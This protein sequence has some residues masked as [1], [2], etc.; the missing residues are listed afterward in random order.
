M[1]KFKRILL[2][3]ISLFIT[4]YL[5]FL[6]PLPL[7]I[8]SPGT[9]FNLKEMIEVDNQFSKSTTNLFLTTV[10]IRQATVFT[11][12]SSVLPFRDLLKEKDLFGEIDN[13]DEYNKVQKIYMENSIHNAIK[14]AFTQAGKDFQMEYKGIYVMQIAENSHFFNELQVGDVIKSV[15]NYQFKNSAEFISY[16]QEKKENQSILIEYERN[17]IKKEARGETILID[18]EKVGIGIGLIDY[19]TVKTSPKVNIHSGEIGGPSAGLMFALQIYTQLLDE[20]LIEGY[21]IAGTGTIDENGDVGRIGGAAKKIVA[22]D[23]KNIDYFFVPNDEITEEMLINNPHIKSNYEEAMEAADAISTEMEIIPVK[24]ISEAISF[25]ENLNKKELS[26]NNNVLSLNKSN[27][28][29]LLVA[30]TLE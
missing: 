1:T 26:K 17:G 8:E 29:N 6:Q 22:A 7:Y 5:I 30:K 15:D 28:Q 9:A 3:T 25:L 11:S 4:L 24:N 13:L 2:K 12:F 23:E 20:D 14:V 27:P 18:P 10:G 19:T 21:N 16:I